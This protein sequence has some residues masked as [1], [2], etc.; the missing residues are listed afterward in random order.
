MRIQHLV[1]CLCGLFPPAVL[2]HP[3]LKVEVVTQPRVLRE[4]KPRYP[5]E[6]ERRRIEGTV[7]VECQVLADGSVGGVR[8]VRSIDRVYGLDQAAMAAVRQWRFDPAKKD[9]VPVPAM[10]T[11]QV[12]FGLAGGP[13]PEPVP[14]MWPEPFPGGSATADATGW[15]NAEMEAEGLAVRFAYPRGWTLRANAPAG[16]WF[17]FV[18]PDFTRLVVVNLPARSALSSTHRMTSSEQ[19]N[20]TRAESNRLRNAG[21]QGVSH[22]AGQVEAAGILWEWMDYSAPAGDPAVPSRFRSRAFGMQG[23]VRIW[24]FMGRTEGHLVSVFFRVAHGGD[25][26]EANARA[27]RE[28]ASQFTEILAQL[29]FK[30]R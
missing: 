11:V 29:S 12:S 5:A 27:E 21:S 26:V 16:T 8:V 1:L 3:Q 23:I 19:Q 13:P 15:M 17:D 6:A 28:A 18:S 7:E 30:E 24:H 14:L 4:V 10:I 2:A 9:N 22:G 20:M 25:D